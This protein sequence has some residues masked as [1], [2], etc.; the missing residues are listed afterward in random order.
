MAFKVDEETHP[1]PNPKRL[2]KI[3]FAAMYQQRHTCNNTSSQEHPL[4]GLSL[5]NNR[6]ALQSC[7]EAL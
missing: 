6:L 7:Q 2:G 5:A 3:R 1:N 4:I